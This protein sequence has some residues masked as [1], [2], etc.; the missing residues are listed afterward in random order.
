MGKNKDAAVGFGVIA[1]IIVVIVGVVMAI[2]PEESETTQN[3]VE[4][5]EPIRI[6]DETVNEPT[7]NV[8]FDPEMVRV[9]EKNIPVMQII[10]RE[11]LKEC[12]AV[13]SYRDYLVLGNA[14]FIVQDEMVQAVEETDDALTILEVLGYDEHPTV[15]PLIKETRRLIGDSG[16]CVRDLLNKYDN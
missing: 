11:V 1:V 7:S 14:I 9:A 10:F 12:N 15:G 5:N 6:Q 13:E 3:E 2:L 8:E 4:K 16:D